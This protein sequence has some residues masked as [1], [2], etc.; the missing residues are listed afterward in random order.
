M[1]N[2]VPGLRIMELSPPVRALEALPTQ[3]APQRQAVPGSK[4]PARVV[5][6]LAPA[7]GSQGILKKAQASTH[8]RT[9]PSLLPALQQK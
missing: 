3:Q 7:V 2:V 9:L 4:V 1:E 8:C 6:G 5:Q